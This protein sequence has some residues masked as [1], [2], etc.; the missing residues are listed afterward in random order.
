MINLT[1]SSPIFP[2]FQFPHLP[3]HI[4]MNIPEFPR[5]AFKLINLRAFREEAD[6]EC[7]F[8]LNVLLGWFEF[9]AYFSYCVDECWVVGVGFDLVSQSRDEAVYAAG[10]YVAIIT[11]H[12]V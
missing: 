7:Q 12:G 11:P 8:Y 6:L 2:V 1:Q 9:V 10:A 4:C 3:S 5:I